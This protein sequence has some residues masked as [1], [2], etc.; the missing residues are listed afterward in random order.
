MAKILIVDDNAI[1]RKVL[2]AALGY[3]G[4]VIL[5]AADGAQAFQLARQDHS[6]SCY[7]RLTLEQYGWSAAKR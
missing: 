4:H 6:R 2:S 5:E 3:E 7:L 1:Y